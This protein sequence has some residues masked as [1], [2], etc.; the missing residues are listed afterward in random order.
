MAHDVKAF[1]ADKLRKMGM[2]NGGNAK[3]RLDKDAAE[4]DFGKAN[5]GESD[6]S[7]PAFKRG[8]AVDGESAKPRM[9]R[10]ARK[11]GGRVGKGKTN[12][13][14]I[15][16]GDKGQQQPQAVPVPVPA[17]G[18][19]MQPPRPPMPPAGLA[20]PQG[21]PPGAGAPGPMPPIPARKCGG[22][23]EKAAGGMVPEK[24]GSRS[25]EGRLEKIKT[26]GKMAKSKP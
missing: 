6:S 24:Y 19:P 22:R 26:E 13:N 21:M 16:G 15:I 5:A 1:T 14:I 9:D 10:A 18:P 4:D 8:G 12:I 11:S 17:G 23:V 2:N 20:G 3:S 25:G 7:R